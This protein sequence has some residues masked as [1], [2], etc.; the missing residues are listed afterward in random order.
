[1]PSSYARQLTPS[2]EHRITKLFVFVLEN[3]PATPFICKSART[4]NRCFASCTAAW[5][6]AIDLVSNTVK[7]GFSKASFLLELA[8]NENGLIFVGD[9]SL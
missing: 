1:M 9:D 3:L 4:T 2:L 8:S 7:G 6:R 5:Q